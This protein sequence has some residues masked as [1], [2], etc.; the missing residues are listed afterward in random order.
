MHKKLLILSV[1]LTMAMVS[2]GWFK[3][4]LD[5]FA[6][7]YRKVLIN[8]EINGDDSV[9]AQAELRKILDADGYTLETFRGQFIEISQKDPEKFTKMLDT[10]RESVA[11]EIVT[12]RSKNK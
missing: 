8:T 1:S 11:K 4:D 5:R 10:M 2:C 9:K 12:I 7:T 6:G 3:S